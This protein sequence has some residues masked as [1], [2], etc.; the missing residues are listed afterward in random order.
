VLEAAGFADAVVRQ[1]HGVW[2]QPN[3]AALLAALCAG[4]ARMAGLI[5]AQ[6]RAALPAIAAWIDVDAVPYRSA[7]ELRLPISA[8]VAGGRKR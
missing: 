5:E 1:H 2:R 7:D 3:G 8:F 6:D 4:T